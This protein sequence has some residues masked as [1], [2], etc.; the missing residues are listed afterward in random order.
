MEKS[1]TDIIAK[2]KTLGKKA[3]LPVS[4]NDI[5][6][7]YFNED[8][9]DEKEQLALSRFDDYRIWYLNSA[10]G[11]LDFHKRYEELQVKANLSQ[12]TEFLDEKYSLPK[13]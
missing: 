12:Y 2:G 5:R 7:K 9:L 3:W 13:Q 8:R 4:I 11:E 6:D 1:W 10:Q